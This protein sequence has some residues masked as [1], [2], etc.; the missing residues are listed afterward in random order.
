MSA[1]SPTDVVVNYA[2]TG[3]ATGIGTDYTDTSAG[4]FTITAGNTTASATIAI[5][6]DAVSEGTE[7]IILTMSPS[8]AVAGATTTHTISIT[9]NDTSSSSGGGGGGG[10]GSSKS[11]V[12]KDPEASNYNL[13]GQHRSWVCKYGVVTTVVTTGLGGGAQCSSEQ[14]LTQNLRSGARDGQYHSYTGTTVFEVKI[15]QAHMN[16]LGFNSGPV[17]GILGPLTDGAIKRMQNFLGTAAD[18]YVGSKTRALINT[19]CGGTGPQQQMY[20]DRY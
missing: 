13:D 1:V 9:D 2:L 10:G 19:S 4:T 8:G 3:T 14:I 11:F 15:L 12:C 5:V 18:G 16:R 17:D 6:D 7:T 20:R